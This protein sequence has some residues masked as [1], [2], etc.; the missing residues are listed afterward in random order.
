MVPGNIHEALAT[1]M[2]MRVLEDA[3]D[4]DIRCDAYFE[5]QHSHAV[6]CRQACWCHTIMS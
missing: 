6:A 1:S 5:A 2:L 4:T 3:Q